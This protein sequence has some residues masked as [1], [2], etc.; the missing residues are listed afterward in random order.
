MALGRLVYVEI[1]ETMPD[2]IQA[3]KKADDQGL[4][5]G[6]AL[7]ARV[8]REGQS[9]WTDLS[10]KYSEKLKPGS[11]LRAGTRVV[12]LQFEKF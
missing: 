1:H 4:K 11:P 7:E 2:A 10:S 6:I 9:L 12:P 5:I 8:D 3:R